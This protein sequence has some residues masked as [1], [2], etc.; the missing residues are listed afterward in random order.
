MM[1]VVTGGQ[2]LRLAQH[3]LPCAVDGGGHEPGR[4]HCTQRQHG[5]H[6]G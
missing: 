6:E 5:Q 3:N 4:D 1:V 2:H